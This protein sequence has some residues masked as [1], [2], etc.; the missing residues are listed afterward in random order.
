MD[1]YDFGPSART[2]AGL[3]AATTDDQLGG[4][5][6]C[7][8]YSVGD[9]IDHIGGLTLEFTYAAR[10]E[11]TPGEG[12]GPAGDR[13]R[14]EPGWRERIGDGLGALATAWDR[15][16]AYDGETHAGPFDMPAPIAA[17]VALNEVVVHGWDLARAIGQDYPADPAAVAVCTD[18]V[19]SFDAPADDDGGLFGPA[20]SVADD[21]PPIDRLVGMTGRHPDWAP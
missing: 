9:L 6:P 1:P 10:K 2:L 14:L 21:A 16:S 7:P 20:V 4:P 19:A 17:Q 15:P 11:P 5:T 8:D 13:S 18:F 12:G 3:V